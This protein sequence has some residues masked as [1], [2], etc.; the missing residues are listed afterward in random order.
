MSDVF[1]AYELAPYTGSRDYEQLADLA[2]QASILCIVDYDGHR[3]VARTNYMQRR[4]QELWSVSARGISYVTAF[5]RADFIA[6]CAHRNL[7]FIAP[8]CP[9][10]GGLPGQ[11]SSA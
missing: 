3:D 11:P 2:V 1:T 9:V 6:L 4:D 5:N 10:D 7:E 8:P